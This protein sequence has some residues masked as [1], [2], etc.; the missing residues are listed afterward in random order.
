MLMEKSGMRGTA[1]A[2]GVDKDTVLR[3]LDHA[4][5]HCEEL[6]DYFRHDPGFTQV[7]VDE[8]YT[9]IQKRAMAKARRYQVGLNPP[10]C[11]CISAKKNVSSMP[12]SASSRDISIS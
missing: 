12:T 1:R 10:G 9:F 8:L 2:I 6:C 7:Q 3:W 5:R 11:P 4:G